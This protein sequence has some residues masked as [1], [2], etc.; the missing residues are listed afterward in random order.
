VTG[1]LPEWVVV[2][3]A[4]VLY[5]VVLGRWLA[6]ITVRLAWRDPAALPSIARVRATRLLL[7]AALWAT[8][9]LT[10]ARPA[11]VG[12]VWVAAAGLVIAGVDLLCHRI[13]DRV[14]YPA[15]AVCSA[16]FLVDAIVLDTWAGLVRAVAAGAVTFGVAALARA[17]AP[18]A[19]GFG[20]V[21]LLGLVALVLGWFS[22]EA[23]LAGLFLGLLTGALV[24]VALMAARRAG[25][26]TAL[27][28]GPPLLVGAA[29]ALALEG[30]VS[31]V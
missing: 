24:S 16:A 28:F 1:D 11:T 6:R 4:S 18:A 29:L 17:S 25:W 23:L 10:G 14:T 22:W 19:L 9:S 27:P 2:A 5:G 30:P 20:D 26:R 13:P 21:K 31:L 12:L 15:L 7:A 3:A 8:V